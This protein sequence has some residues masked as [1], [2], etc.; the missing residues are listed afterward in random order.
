[1]K[2]QAL[3]AVVTQID[4]TTLGLMAVMVAIV[5]FLSAF[6]WQLLLRPLRFTR[7]TLEIIR[8]QMV[9]Q[10]INMLIP[11]GLG[12]DF[13]K[14]FM[15]AE[16]PERGVAQTLATVGVERLMG[17]F[18]LGVLVALMILN[19]RLASHLPGPLTQFSTPLLLGIFLIGIAG[20]AIVIKLDKTLSS[21]SS[22]M[23]VY[24]NAIARMLNAVG[25]YRSRPVT[26]LL[27]FALSV[28]C[29]LAAAFGM[30]LVALQFHTISFDMML[31]VML[32]SFLMT[33]IPVTIGGLGTRELVF[34]FMLQ[35]EGFSAEAATALSLCWFVVNTVVA[36]ALAAGFN[37]GPGVSVDQKLFSIVKERQNE[38]RAEM[39]EL[40]I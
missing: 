1:V 34:V 7:S 15:V 18:A 13:I 11:G 4:L 39:D 3:G 9:G 33:L 31:L 17:V 10:G 21:K 24:I 2:P 5:A 26:L 19:P 22:A 40:K 29:H 25:A 35:P 23:R 28:L 32:V 12:G 38:K 37:L 27:A 30:W 14:V 8:A 20:A 6:R 36:I 16:P